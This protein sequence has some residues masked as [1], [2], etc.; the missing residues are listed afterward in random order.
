MDARRPEERGNEDEGSGNEDGEKDEEG[1]G[2]VNE[3]NS[4]PDWCRTEGVL[5]I[6]LLVSSQ[7]PI[8]NSSHP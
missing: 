1:E 2:R 3:D 6:F 8:V 5:I 4:L 7:K